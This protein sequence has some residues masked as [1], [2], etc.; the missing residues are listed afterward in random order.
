MKKRDNITFA[1]VER[2]LDRRFAE[3]SVKNVKCC[4]AWS[5]N[6]VTKAQLVK[7]ETTRRLQTRKTMENVA[8]T[9]AGIVACA[10]FAFV[11]QSANGDFLNKLF[12][13]SIMS[14]CAFVG[15]FLILYLHIFIAAPST[16]QPTVERH[17]FGDEDD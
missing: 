11:G 1:W 9:I 3:E 13:A 7:G 15:T 2:Q 10:T 8:A 14:V 17:L 6:F 16:H 4:S 5:N 12:A